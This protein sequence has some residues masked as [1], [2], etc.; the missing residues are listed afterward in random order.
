MIEWEKNI[1]RNKNEQSANPLKRKVKMQA[2]GCEAL[3][4]S[5]LNRL[6]FTG[7]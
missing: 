2:T 3:F 6:D 4:K 7:F 5:K 1:F